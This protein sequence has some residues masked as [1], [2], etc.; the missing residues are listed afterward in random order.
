MDFIYLTIHKLS[1]IGTETQQANPVYRNDIRSVS[2]LHAPDLHDGQS[3]NLRRLLDIR[4]LHSDHIKPAKALLV[5]LRPIFIRDILS[6][7]GYDN[8]PAGPP[9]FLGQNKEL[10]AAEKHRS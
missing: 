3:K 10:V 9:L 6:L 1:D 4:L 8:L 2:G 7:G 5:V